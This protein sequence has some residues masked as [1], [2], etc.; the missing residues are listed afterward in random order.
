VALE[1][2]VAPGVGREGEPK[3]VG[4]LLILEVNDEIVRL[5]PFKVGAAPFVRTPE[6][7]RLAGREM[8]RELLH[9]SP[10]EEGLE[11]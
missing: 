9:V 5:H 4:D 7:D 6:K 2:R 11:I 1:T 10:A 3:Y 8:P